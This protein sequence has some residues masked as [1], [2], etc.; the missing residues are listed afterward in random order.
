[1]ASPLIVVSGT[2]RQPELRAYFSRNA[3]HPRVPGKGLTDLMKS[4]PSA[5]YRK[6]EGGW[7]ITGIGRFDADAVFE[8][9]GFEIDFE[10]ETYDTDL[11]GIDNL[12]ELVPPMFHLAKDSRTVLVRHRLL[13][14]D[15]TKSLLGSGAMWDRDRKRFYMPVGDLLKNG[16]PR[17]GLDIPEDALEAAWDQHDRIHTDSDIVKQASK[18]ALAKDVSDLTSKEIGA[19]VGRVGDIPEW[20]GLPLYPYQR[21]G[22]IAVAAGHNLLADG[23]RVGKALG[24]HTRVL[25]PRGFVPMG[26]IR[27]GDLVIGS[28]GHGTEVTGVF[29]QGAR[30]EYV[31]ELSDRSEVRADGEHLWTVTDET[32]ETVT[33]TTLEVGDRLSRGSAL[34]LPE[35]SPVHYDPRLYA[36]QEVSPPRTP[37]SCFERGALAGSG[38]FAAAET[39]FHAPAELRQALLE[40]SISVSEQTTEGNVWSLRSQRAVSAI[41]E[42]ARSLGRVIRVENEVVDGT[43]SGYI[44]TLHPAGT[45][46]RIVG[47]SPLSRRAEMI[48]ISVAAPD[49][50]FVIDEFVLTHN[51]RTSLAVAAM[52]DARRTLIVCP[53]VVLTNW[54]RN[55][56]ECLLATLGGQ[57]PEGKLVEFRAGRKEP[58]LPESGIVLIADSL[59]TSRTHVQDALVDWSPDVL[60]YDE[61]IDLD[62]PILTTEGWKTVGGIQEGDRVFSPDGSPVV[63]SG[64]TP[65]K[66]DAECFRVTLSDGSSV[67]VDAGHLWLAEPKTLGRG[68]KYLDPRVISTE[69]LRESISSGRVWRLPEVSPLESD[70]K[71]LPLPPYVLGVWLGD[72]SLRQPH[73]AVA[74][75]RTEDLSSELRRHWDDV[76]T[77]GTG[78]D[79]ADRLSLSDLGGVGGNPSRFR[80]AAMEAGVWDDKHIPDEYLLASVDQRIDLLRGLMDTDGYVSRVHGKLRNVFVFS[81]SNRRIID[82]VVYLV[83]SLGMI[84]AVSKNKNYGRGKES[85]CWRVSFSAPSGMSLFSM[86]NGDAVFTS[87][88][89][90]KRRIISVDPVESRRVRCIEVDS[91]DHLFLVGRSLIPTHNCHR[92]KNFESA[93]TRAVLRVA[94]ASEFPLPL[95]GT[96]LFQT[97]QELAPLLEMTG[98]LTPVF[99]GLESYLE[100]YCWQNKW[101]G[102]VPRVKT[103]PRLR[104]LLDTYVWVR[105]TKDQVLHDLPK[106]SKGEIDLD[107]D[108]KLFNAAHKDVSDSLS[109]WL[110]GFVEEF[111]RL[112]DDEEI[113]DYAH[114]EGIRYISKMR[115]AAGL[116]KVPAAVEYIRD[117]VASTTEI[118]ENG[119]KV[120]TRPLLVWTHHKEVSEEM[121]LV[122]PNEVDDAAIIMGGISQNK[123]QRLIDEFQDGR[124]PVLVCQI[125]AAGVGIDLTR[126]SDAVFVETDWV[127]ALV[128]Q[129]EERVQGVNQKRPVMLTTMV[130]RGTL[131]DR[132]QRIQ[133]EKSKVL[134]PLLGG[135]NDVSVVEVSD[136]EANSSAIL[137]ELIDAEIAKRRKG[138]KR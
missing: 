119:K 100:T 19:L 116:A 115:R 84:P 13:G 72:G 23:M 131:D 62:E 102:W 94:A 34:A 64:L 11:E 74:K 93:R 86:R 51:T 55:V 3:P 47:V 136:D 22:A 80:V 26:S 106:V 90:L 122:V 53:P 46:R 91:E 24:A 77:I 104:K 32:G 30:D 79:K 63:V 125:S 1:M 99:G 69:S 60:I 45:V 15:K 97:P 21:V 50:L 5:Y 4:F 81:N 112:P 123:R 98:H 108:L 37:E 132:I 40:G 114:D 75:D 92:A 52:R 44:V 124:I 10:S 118:D 65:I 82:G 103:L 76:R 43:L 59:L 105:R 42:I 7:F 67:V 71:S 109:E 29:P 20:F 128:Q 88:K 25:T 48:C 49:H 130:A 138:K 38:D 9:A 41:V 61:A 2:F 117:H 135:K 110:D 111:R 14:F 12:D 27:R 68:G 16:E 39:Y 121:S 6:S 134:D 95:T 89:P 66:D 33:L 58:E 129:A 137:I 85:D 87:G 54:Q 35:L 113:A 126:S 17:E 78:D 101:G 120:Y 28:N 127:P 107:I 36:A 57:Y 8:R 133:H 18:A 70:E 73:I 56:D 83:R 96:P 31:L